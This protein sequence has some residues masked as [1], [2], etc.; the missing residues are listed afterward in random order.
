MAYEIENYIRKKV[1]SCIFEDLEIDSSLIGDSIKADNRTIISVTELE[2]NLDEYLVRVEKEDI[3]IE[4]Q[5][6]V[7]AKMTNPHKENYRKIEEEK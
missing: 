3:Y 2:K 7:I 1:K 5:G 4:Q 6:R